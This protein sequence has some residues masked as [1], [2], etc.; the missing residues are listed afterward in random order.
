[1]QLAVQLAATALIVS[2]AT[3][4]E[5]GSHSA[6][7]AAMASGTRGAFNASALKDPCA[8][9]M[10]RRAPAAFSMAFSTQYGTFEAQCIRA[11][12]PVWADR[13][14]GLHTLGY[15]DDNYMFRVIPGKYAQFGTSRHGTLRL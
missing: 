13:V 2:V 9:A 14:Y 12:A 15:Y 3:A 6:P 10:R 7:R 4:T 1:M 8:P 11:R 5:D